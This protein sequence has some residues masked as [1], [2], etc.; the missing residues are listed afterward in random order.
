MTRLKKASPRASRLK[1][2]LSPHVSL[3]TTPHLNEAQRE[4]ITHKTG[5]LLVIAG[6]GTGKTR[7]I[8]ERI[9]HIV[10]SGWCKNDEV[11]ALTFTEKAT[12]E[13]E[14]RVNERMPLGYEAI[15]IHTFHG[16][17]DKILRQFGMDIGISSGFKILQGV[18]HWLF[19]KEHL[20]EFE[21]DYYRPLGNPTS[22]ID[23][24]LSAFSRLKEELNAPSDVVALAEKKAKA[25][26][27]QEEKLEEKRLTELAHAYVKYQELLATNDLLDYTDLQSKVIELFTRRPNILKHLQ[28]QYQ[29]IL[30]DEYQDT[31]I[32]QNRI[33][34]LLA[35][36]HRNLMVVGDDDQSIYKFRGAAIS[37]ILQFQENYPE[38]KKIVLTQ[39]YRSNQ[40]ILDFAY[41]S[42]QNN[43]PDRLEVKA[44]VNKKLIG[45]GPG[46]EDSVRLVHCS[47]VEEESDHVIEEILRRS[48][49]QNDS[50]SII[51]LGEIAILTRTNAQAQVFTEALKKANIPYQFVSERGL[52]RKAEIL[53]LI[54]VLRV[55]SNPKD[56]L[57]FYRVMRMEVFNLSMEVI[58]NVIAESKK[59]FQPVWQKLKTVP[60]AQFLADTLKDVLE[61]SKN[62]TAGETLYRFTQT[63]KLYEF[64]LAKNTLEAEEK[65]M[66]IASFFSKIREFERGNLDNSVID[67]VAYLDLAEEAGENPSAKFQIEDRDGVFVSTVHGAKGLEFDTVFLGSCTNDRFPAANRKDSIQIPDELV[68]EILNEKDSHIEEE[69]RLF[70]VAVTRAK[71]NLHLL[72][73]DHYGPSASQ[74]PR[75]KKRSRF[76]DEVVDKVP[77]LQIERTA[78]GSIEEFLRPKSAEFVIEPAAAIQ[79]RTRITQF[80]Y[81]QLTAFKD[82]PRKYQYSYLYKIP[83][84]QAAALSFGTSMHNTLREFYKTVEQQKQASLFT[85]FEPDLSLQRLLKIYDEKWVEGGYESKA[86]MEL[87]KVRGR[88]ILTAFYDKFKND[89]PRIHFLEKGFKLKIGEYTL[90]GRLD[91]ADDLPDSTLEIIDYKTGRSKT[92]DELKNDLQ[93]FIY[94]LASQ[95]CFNLPASR[96]TLYFLDDD[97]RVSV[98]PTAEKM[99]EVKA[100][101]KSVADA[102]NRSDFAP[103]P[104]QRLCSRCPF[105]KICDASMAYVVISHI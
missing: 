65:I 90:S 96:L 99:E 53:D 54:A 71:E 94:A 42:I 38:A 63:I 101:I 34:D 79:S 84:P 19:M 55:L 13:I 64:L 61:F 59:T 40:R 41:A 70:Y 92:E 11:L 67:F 36:Q 3:N 46:L 24:L 62:H 49:S 17:C 9:A 93:L 8:T 5:P 43:N 57:S 100:E 33:V 29:Y 75:K 48:A 66:N 89:I 58:V 82:C 78:S 103:T 32:A 83:E 27:T 73:S 51:P 68:H 88:E 87:R 16:F 37:N 102:I 21:L 60:V 81:S 15:S 98:V 86:H 23:A 74:N 22:F 50:Q 77:L 85:E 44:G 25:A 52:Y 7:V 20:F 35:A 72:Y 97:K 26:Q 30:V 18:E 80:S 47:T 10:N 105:N 12:A 56:D 104:N 45:R 14:D 6:A 31:N 4:A 1:V 91:R 76:I 2:K 28:K 69:R 39:N 95:E